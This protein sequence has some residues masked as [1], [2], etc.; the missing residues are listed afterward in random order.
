MIETCSTGRQKCSP[1]THRNGSSGRSNRD[2]KNK[3]KNGVFFFWF[4]VPRSNRDPK[5]RGKMVS[6]ILLDLAGE[7]PHK[8]T[9]SY[10]FCNAKGPYLSR[11]TEYVNGTNWEIKKFK[12]A[13][14]GVISRRNRAFHPVSVQEL[15]I[16]FLIKSKRTVPWS[17][18]NCPPCSLNC[19]LC[20]LNCSLSCSTCALN[21]SPCAAISTLTSFTSVFIF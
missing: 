20:A 12:I 2:V 6:T 15:D 13:A 17:A 5:T 14:D 19:S 4:W 3:D 16:T 10:R 11:I 7:Q 8:N 21:F 9:D 18:P 1:A